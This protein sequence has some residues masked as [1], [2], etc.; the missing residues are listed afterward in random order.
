[1]LWKERRRMKKK[2]VKRAVCVLL[3]AGMSIGLVACSGKEDSAG[4]VKVKDVER[5]ASVSNGELDGSST[6]VGVGNTKVIYDEY[7]MYS[8]FLKNQYEDVMSAQ[9]WD[10]RL[11]D[12]TVGQYAIEDIL[13]LIIQIKVMN[14]EAALQGIGLGVDEKE[15]IDHKADEY[16][17]TVPAEVQQA[18]G[19]T[20]EGLHL[21]FEEN[22]IARKM[23]DVVTGN[24]QASVDEAALQAVKVQML[25][26]PADDSNRE[27]V[28]AQANALAAQ[29]QA[30][31][32]NFYSFVRDT[33]GAGPEEEIIGNM[34]LRVNLANAA[35]S[36]ERYMASPV[37]EEKDGF[38]LMYCLKKNT[39]GL[40][41]VYREQYVTEQQNLT[42][43]AAYEN[44][45][46]KYEVKVSKSLLNA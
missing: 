4:E 24:V 15:D 44:W 37:V 8:W 23:Y 2:F 27:Q 25:Y 43:Q 39:K 17:A 45:A 41:K 33:T 11:G 32:G 28:R 12:T 14:K 18:N 5:A 9:V 20:T 36:L 10:Y 42:F 3:L 19:I 26:L 22:E 46:E 30:H 6:V 34:D 1:M 16:L 38:Y 35:L 7:R 40:K 21:I 29:L 13:R 31:K